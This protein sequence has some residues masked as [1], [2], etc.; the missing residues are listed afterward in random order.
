M[1]VDKI[2]YYMQQ[3]DN[4]GSF[5]GIINKGNWREVN[6]ALTHAGEIRGGHFHKKTTQIIFLTRGKAEVKLEDLKHLGKSKKFILQQGE[7]I[8]IEPYVLHTLH[9]LED[10]EHIALLD[11]PLES[12]KPDIH[13]LQTKE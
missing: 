6:L 9:Y 7:G 3:K 5:Q 10:S 8:K 11:R 2:T 4:R 1:E 12:S 13:T